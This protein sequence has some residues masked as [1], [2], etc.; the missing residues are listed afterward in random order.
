VS[1]YKTNGNTASIKWVIP[2]TS[3]YSKGIV[4]ISQVIG[5]NTYF[6]NFSLKNYN[7]KLIMKFILMVFTF[8]I[9][10]LL[11]KFILNKFQGY[12]KKHIKYG[13]YSYPLELM[14]FKHINFLDESV[15]VPIESEQCLALTYGTD[16]KT[17]KKDY[18]WYKEASNL[19]NL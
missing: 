9:Q 18:I 5:K 11:P 14:K 10:I 6:Y 17:P 19:I 15:P 2:N 16:W 4:F 13:G 1:F 3:F 7:I 8:P 12:A